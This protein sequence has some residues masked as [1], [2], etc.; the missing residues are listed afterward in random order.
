[1]DD[2]LEKTTD[3]KPTRFNF[4]LRQ[5]F[6]ATALIACGLAL[7]P[8]T[9]LPTII[10][11]A[12]WSYV[13]LQ[14]N[15]NRAVIAVALI[16][17]FFCLGG[18]MFPAVSQVREAARRTHCMNNMRQIMLAILNHE[19]AYG[20]FPT[21][22][23]VTLADGTELRH[24]WRVLILPFLESSPVYDMYDFNEPWD[25][26]NNS[27]L[28]T[29]T[30]WS[31]F[32][33]PSHDS[34]TKTPYKLVVGPGTAFEIGNPH[35]SADITD[36]T[37]NTIALVEDTANPVNWMEPSDLS[38]DQAA[39]IL[40]GLDRKSCSHGSETPFERRL[41]GSNLGILDGST[42]HWMAKPESLLP[43]GSFL[44]D[45][46]I[47]FDWDIVGEALVETKYGGYVALGIYLLLVFL[48]AFYLRKRN[49]TELAN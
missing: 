25:G 46:G 42:C 41:T 39:K 5:L 4:G 20:H 49:D 44:I 1:M 43:A 37:S 23:V 9:I 7:G 34:G 6:Y 26:P 29:M 36:G 2:K 27:K 11:L 18:L 19:S 21:D 31:V 40:N 14:R 12:C 8:G 10:V 48:P 16:L 3:G 33:C 17:L 15:R 45:D 28:E 24:S 30:F 13:F 38:P 35:N 22:R 47:L 32:Q